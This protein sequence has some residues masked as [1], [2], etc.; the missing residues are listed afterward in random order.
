MFTFK[1]LRAHPLRVD[2]PARL[3]E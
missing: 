1:S 3:S 2:N